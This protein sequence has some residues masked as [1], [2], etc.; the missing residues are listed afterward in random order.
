MTYEWFYQLDDL[1]SQE[2]NNIRPR[3]LFDIDGKQLYRETMDRLAM[4]L[5]DGTPSPFSSRNP[6][7]AEGILMEHVIFLMQMQMHEANLIPDYVYVNWLRVW[8]IEMQDADYP[9]IDITFYRSSGEYDYGTQAAIIPVGTKVFSNREADLHCVTTQY[10]EIPSSQS[11]V[12]VPARLNRRGKISPN[13][14]AGEFVW[15]QDLLNYVDRAQGTTI[16]YPGRDAETLSQAVLRARQQLQMPTGITTDRH[17]YLTALWSGAQKARVLPGIEYTNPGYDADMISIVV[18]PPDVS[19]YV[20]EVM[21]DRKLSG[22]RVGV[23]KSEIIPLNGTIDTRIVSSISASQVL[24]EAASVVVNQINP[25]YG[26]WGDRTFSSSL[27]S[28]LV[29]GSGNIYGIDNMNLFHAETGQPL[30][31]LEA[32]IKLGALFK[33]NDSVTFNWIR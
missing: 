1:L 21:V 11:S 30:A 20:Q 9:R 32:E 2:P 12:V 15:L 33:L 13:I 26:S 23:Y 22:T 16:V 19:D 28:A 17:Y 5:A 7:T 31:E 24:T 4:P 14:S 6:L 3:R 29:Q 10:A 27:A 8:G 18:Y 25:P